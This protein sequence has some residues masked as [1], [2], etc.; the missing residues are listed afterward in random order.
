M[1][2]TSAATADT[3]T[4][5]TAAPPRRHPAD[6]P[7]YVRFD[8]RCEAA[9]ILR[10]QIAGLVEGAKYV[11]RVHL[12]RDLNTM[13]EESRMVSLAA[14]EQVALVQYAVD[15]SPDCVHAL[16]LEVYEEASQDDANTTLLAFA[17][18]N[19]VVFKETGQLKCIM[20]KPVTERAIQAPAFSSQF[21]PIELLD[22]QVPFVDPFGS[23]ENKCV[24][25]IQ[26]NESVQLQRT[27]SL[28]PAGPAMHVIEPPEAVP[29]AV[30]DRC[31]LTQDQAVVVEFDSQFDPIELLGTRVPFV[32]PFGYNQNECRASGNT[33]TSITDIL[34]PVSERPGSQSISAFQID[35]SMPLQRTQSLPSVMTMI[36]P[37][38]AVPEVVSQRGRLSPDQAIRVFKLRKTKMARTASQRAAKYGISAKAIRDIWTRKSWVQ[39]TRPFWNE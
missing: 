9:P 27:Q 37:P 15:L 4:A 13:L 18:R 16:V 1:S 29:E 30:S 23:I 36:E 14:S 38:E 3:A 7:V 24:S 35:E 33:S 5:D 22:T 32:D 2:H 8:L 12:A 26:G 11:T 31:R 28:P 34:S 6:A 19:V 20:E 25:A 17:K 39:D 21:D 10:V